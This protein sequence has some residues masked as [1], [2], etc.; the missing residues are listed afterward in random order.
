MSATD[1]E[2]TV[3]LDGLR[4]LVKELRESSREAEHQVGLSAAQ[5]FVLEVLGAQ[6]SLSL[7]EVAARTHTHQS[8]VSVVVSRLVKARLVRRVRSPDDGR[9]LELAL[10]A[11]GRTLQEKAPHV[12]QKRL[13]T[14]VQL[15]PREQRRAL[16]EGLAQVAQLMALSD[17]PAP[18]FFDDSP[19]TVKGK[20]PR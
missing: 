4:R 5:L 12:A 1:H 14:A 13:V 6:S 3:V 10:T 16:G 20:K 19:T 9:R 2:T 15:L 18:M 11:K 7:S 17:S 8:S